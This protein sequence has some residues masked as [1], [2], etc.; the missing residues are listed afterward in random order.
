[1]CV[2]NLL[3]AIASRFE[4]DP[5]TTIVPPPKESSAANNGADEEMKEAHSDSSQNTEELW[6]DREA[7]MLEED[8]DGFQEDI[9]LMEGLFEPG[10]KKRY[11]K[12]LAVLA[13]HTSPVN[14]VRWNSLGTLFVSA[15]DDG[16]IYL[17]EYVGEMA[18]TSAFQKFQFNME[19]PSQN[20][21]NMPPTGGREESKTAELPEEEQIYEEWRMKKT[22]HGSRGGGVSDLAWSPD[23]IHF[24]T[25]GTDSQIIIWS[26][27]ESCKYPS[28]NV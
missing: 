11:Q 12:L 15:S 21:T 24:T 13:N 17:F 22:W 4:R 16:F 20:A 1:V 8:E 18:V 25:C 2:W 14:C 9:A 27:N 10:S 7:E 3:P 5:A 6:R 19:G 23:N 26:I 28:L